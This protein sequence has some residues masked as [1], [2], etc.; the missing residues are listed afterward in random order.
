[1]ADR[2]DYFFRQKVTEAE[3]DE[4]FDKMEAADEKLMTD[5]LL[6]GIF[7]GGA[8]AE[9]FP[10]ADLT[11]DIAG[12]LNAYD[13]NGQRIFFSPLQVLDMSQDENGVSTAVGTPGNEKVLAIFVEFDRLLSDPRLDGNSNTVFFQRAESFKLN[14]V[15][16][17]EA[18]I[19]T[20]VPPPL[21][22][23]QLL[24]ADVTIINAQTAIL[25]ADIDSSRREDVFDITGTPNSI[26]TGRVL[27]ALQEFQDQLND[28]INGGASSIGYAGG[29]DWADTTTNPST[30]VEAQLDKI[31]TD[32]ATGS[33]TAKLAGIASGVSNEILAAGTLKAQLELLEAEI[34]TGGDK[35]GTLRIQIPL[36]DLRA[37]AGAPAWVFNDAV[38]AGDFPH[39]SAASNSS[40]LF[41]H[42][43]T[44]EGDNVL[45]VEIIVENTS[46]GVGVDIELFRYTFSVTTRVRTSLSSVVNVDGLNGA[47]PGSVSPTVPLI[48][49]G[50]STWYAVEATRD[51]DAGTGRIIAASMD[52]TR[53]AA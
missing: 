7:I 41:I 12:P 46:S 48:I 49:A 28:I 18:V 31:I 51:G 32:L 36:T 44:K 47:L 27:D 53:V 38:A 45:S 16:S 40:I 43:P 34:I 11:V 1:M 20:A 2:L 17:A 52:V 35:S 15:Q 42:L 21:R 19:P 3:L 39:W 23:D 22:I 33:G 25:N 30:D 8:V 24:L 50:G 6:T 13:Q 10:T 26:K 4:G 29:P 5:Q 37:Q 14:V 9:H